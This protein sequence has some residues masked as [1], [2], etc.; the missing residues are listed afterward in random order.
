MENLILYYS[1]TCPYCVKVLRFLE[2]NG[3]ELELRDRGFESNRS[4]LVAIGGKA[5]VPCLI[6]NGSPMYESDDIIDYFT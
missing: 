6:I 1:P 5:Q 2:D 3:I 4:D